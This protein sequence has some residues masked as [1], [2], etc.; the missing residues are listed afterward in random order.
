MNSVVKRIVYRVELL[1]V[2]PISVSS[3]YEGMTDSDV[4]RDY[5]GNPFISGSSIAGAFRAYVQSKNNGIDIFGF[6]NDEDGKMSP[7]FISDLKFNKSETDIRD[8]VALDDN[9]IT[10]EGAK[11]DFEVL[12]G[13]SKGYFYIELTI[14]EKDNEELLVSTLNEIFNGIHLK[15]IRL[16]NNKTRGYGIIDIEEIKMREFTK[17]NF[18]E[19]KDCYSENAWNN[20]PKYKLDYSTKGH[21]MCIEVPLRLKGGISIRKY[22]VRKGAPDFE[23]ITDHGSPVIP[24][25]SIMGALRH[26]IKE[27]IKE[28]D[29]DSSYGLYPNKMIDEMFGFVSGKDAHISG[30]IVDEMV[31]EGAKALEM[32]RTGISRFENSARNG[33]LYKEKTYVDGVFTLRLSVCR[34]NPN[35]EWIIGILLLAVKDLQN[36][37]LA[38]GGQTSIGRGIFEANGPL[39]IDGEEN[40]EDEYIASSIVK[41]KEMDY[42]H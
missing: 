20:E 6:A 8:S 40:K 13:N 23:H 26:R 39:T 41:Y 17:N 18:L 37:F 36:G 38:V 2:S 9:K 22:A 5:D 16:G 1:F 30:V 15:E 3:G 10:K 19:Y 27:I 35:V 31:I 11:F 42:E 12:Q 32:T 24:G 29:K 25:T 7:V 34:E 14:R 4:L 33:A 28:L 21:W